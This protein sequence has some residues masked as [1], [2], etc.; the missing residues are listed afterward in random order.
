VDFRILAATNR[1]LREMVKQG[2]FGADLYERLAVL[3]INLPPLRERL[4]DLP[5]LLL[6][7]IER[8]YR[9]EPGIKG[10]V[11]S[12]TP[13]AMR[14]LEAYPWPGNIRE[15]R[16]VVFAVLAAKRAGD[17]ILLSDL[18][19]RVL[20]RT[21][22]PSSGSIVDASA[23]EKAVGA[24]TFS[25]RRE[26]D[27]LEQAALRAALERAGGNVSRA[28]R[29]LGEIGRG[30]PRDPGGTVRAMIRRLENRGHTIRS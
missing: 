18:P 29:L 16:N 26:V 15:L 19:R 22:E 3:A 1:D 17:E 28:A 23:V 10:R 13:E 30:S 5:T 11:D 25:L 27:A 21:P 20:R 12:V 4:E 6:H 2:A 9:E 8:F 7:L 24:G 14:A